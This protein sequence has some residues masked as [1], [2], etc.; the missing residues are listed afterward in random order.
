MRWGFT[1]HSGFNALPKSNKKEQQQQYYNMTTKNATMRI[2][3]KNNAI[4]AFRFQMAHGRL[5]YCSE[6]W[7]YDGLII[8]VSI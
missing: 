5:L 8:R 2:N 4:H 6:K 1:L 7:G 3:P